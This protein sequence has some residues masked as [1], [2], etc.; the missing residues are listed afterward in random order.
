MSFIFIR[1]GA[2]IM[3]PSSKQVAEVYRRKL[4]E[5]T[6]ELRQTRIELEKRTKLLQ[7]QN[8]EV[9][10]LSARLLCA[11]DQERRRIAR[12]L[13]DSLGQRL[14]LL[15]FDLSKLRAMANQVNSTFAEAISRALSDLKS[16]GTEL[17][18]IS[19]LLH[20][21]LLDDLGLLSALRCYVEGFQKRSNIS[22]RLQLPN[23][24]RRLPRSLETTIFRIAQECLANVFRHSGSPTASMELRCLPGGGVSLVVSDKG[25]GMPPQRLR[26]IGNGTSS[27]V[28]LRGIEER[29]QLF[30]GYMEI[31]SGHP[32]TV[33]RTV[34]PSVSE[35][36]FAGAE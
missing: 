9:R 25:R 3:I 4:S 22:V 36:A 11:Q 15:T 7:T 24:M 10:T 26:Q 6:S 21:P 13:H 34:I 17:R 18:T 5:R 31:I 28:G 2:G 32:G 14:I 12:E 1:G 20:P 27:G 19:Y 33:I 8:Q 29:V 16:V 35:S 30:G 23:E